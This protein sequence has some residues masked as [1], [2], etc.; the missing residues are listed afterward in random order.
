M[1]TIWGSHNRE[2]NLSSGSFYF[3]KCNSDRVY[4][5]KRIAK[6]FTLYFIPL[7]QLENLGEIIQCQI[8]TT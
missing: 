4:K 8:L 5:R 6:Y 7:F 3:S 2:T 1:F